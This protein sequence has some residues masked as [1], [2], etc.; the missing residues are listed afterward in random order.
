MA[1]ATLTMANLT[2]VIALLIAAATAAS[3]APASAP[4]TGYTNHT[5]GGAVG[6]FFNSTTNTSATNYSAWAANQT[7]NLGDYLIFISISNTTV[8][9][10]YNETVYRNCTMDEAEDGDT[11]QYDGGQN[12]FEKSLTVAVPLT[13]VGTNYY[14]S[15]AD[16]GAQCQSGMAFE[17]Q[18]NHGLGL[19][20]YLNQPPPP[21]YIE[22]PGPDTAQSPPTT[23]LNS[24]ANSGFRGGASL[25]GVLCVSFF[26]LFELLS[27]F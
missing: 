3:N 4:V 19:P 24:P 23:I 18:V 25:T 11:F 6:W 16:D 1:M 13:I 2:V 20:P 9:Q 12:Q 27:V 17:I 7:F 21:P 14:F 22:P 26:I 8:I 10:T 5:V 15:D